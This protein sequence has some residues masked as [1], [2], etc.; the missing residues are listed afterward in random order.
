MKIDFNGTTEE[1]AAGT[2][3]RAFLDAHKLTGP[4]LILEWNGE[5]LS[6]PQAAEAVLNDGDALNV[7]SLVGG[8]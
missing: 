1:T 2:T 3:I 8:G 7:F 4:N 6:L 5:I